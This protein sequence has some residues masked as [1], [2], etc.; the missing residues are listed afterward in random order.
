MKLL[1][2]EICHKKSDIRVLK[3]EFNSS[4]SSLQNEISF[5]DFAHV[6]SLFLRIN[7]R[8]LASKSAT[9]QKKLSKLVKSNISMQDSCK[10]IFNFSKYELSD[11]EKRLLVKGL[12]FSL[13]P[14]YLDYTDYLVNFELFYRN[15]CNL[16]ILSNEGLD[17]VKARTKEA[18]LSSYRNYN[19]NVPQHLSKEEFLALQNLRKNKNIVI[20]K[21]D[22]GNSVVIFDKADY[23]VKMG[24][25]LNDTQK[26]EKINLKNDGILNFAVN[27]EKYVDNN[28]KK[29][30]YS[31]SEETRNLLNELGLG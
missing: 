9:Q 6:S 20:Q 30:L 3:N 16:G 31:I 12:N 7:N 24:N 13:P 15:V 18:A 4:H 28:F 25:L 1:Q 19:N 11:F 22:K 5:I 8:I 21:S 2:K 14:K 27:Q 29:L 23:L 10:V 26:F 17:F